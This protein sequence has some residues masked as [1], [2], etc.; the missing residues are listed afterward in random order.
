MSTVF[1]SPAGEPG[2]MT[3]TTG[4]KAALFSQDGQKQDIELPPQIFAADLNMSVL[5]ESVRSRLAAVRAG[6]HS[7]KTRAEVRGGGVKPWR[8]KGT[9]RARHGSIREPQWVGGGIAHGPKP[10]RY[11]L[12][13]N[14]KARA[15]ALRS[16]LS[17]RASQGRVV[18]VEMPPFDAPKTKRAA[19]LLRQ[20]NVEGKVLIVFSPEEREASINAWKS[21]TNLPLALPVAAPSPYTVLEAETVVFTRR[22]LESMAG[23]NPEGS[24]ADSNGGESAGSKSKGSKQ[25]PD[26]GEQS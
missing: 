26:L 15:A 6:T 13:V 24:P 14:K 11:K 23:E 10:R 19:E 9:G 1:R 17:D 8:Q 4:P 5:H 22:A 20:W 2:A 21:F 3:E 18:V 25:G 7:T 12:R 16:S